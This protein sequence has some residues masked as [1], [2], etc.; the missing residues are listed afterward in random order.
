MKL[1]RFLLLFPVL[2]IFSCN[3]TYYHEELNT[4][5][6]YYTVFSRDWV[7]ADAPPTPDDPNENSQWTFFYCDFPEPVLTN[8][9]FDF[10]IMDSYLTYNNKSIIT[11]LP[12]D[13]FFMAPNGFT[14][15]EQV[16]CEFSPGS[17]RFI[18]KYSD[19][20]MK[21]WPPTYNFMVRYAW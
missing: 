6:R 7:L 1:F 21:A 13:N 19:F 17:V 3:N 18:V 5:T 10:G 4:E 2:F 20:N 9:I 12:F 14:W 11:P 16:T 15:T 8:K